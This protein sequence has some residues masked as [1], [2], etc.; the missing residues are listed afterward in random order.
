MDIRDT[1]NLSLA[2]WFSLYFRLCYF[3]DGQGVVDKMQ[4][5]TF[6]S[7]IVSSQ[8]IASSAQMTRK[9]K[10]CFTKLKKICSEV[11]RHIAL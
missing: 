4:T 1:I 2:Q 6:G 11:S 10:H 9:G 8:Q 5:G 3:I 7:V